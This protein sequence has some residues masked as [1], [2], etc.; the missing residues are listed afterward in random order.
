GFKRQV[1][2][3]VKANQVLSIKEADA[4]NVQVKEAI[5][6]TIFKKEDPSSLQVAFKHEDDEF[7]D[8]KV[9]ATLPKKHSQQGRAIASG[10]I[11]GDG[12]ED[13]IIG[14]SANKQAVGYIQMPN[15]SFKKFQLPVKKEEDIGLL[16]F[17]ADNDGDLDLYC[18]S[19]GSDFG[20]KGNYQDRLYLNDGRGQF[21][22]SS[23]APPAVSSGSTVIAHDFDHDGDLDLFVGGRIRP[24]EYPFA[25]DSYILQNDGKGKF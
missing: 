1:L 14:G 11:N 5:Q 17:D 19:G 25:P 8:F 13:F 7:I 9:T 18:V 16:L 2:T 23:N 20:K 15:G 21:S 6:P 10:D 24:E 12:L 4:K 22:L 3:N